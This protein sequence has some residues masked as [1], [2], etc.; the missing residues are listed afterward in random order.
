MDGKSLFITFEGIDGTGKSTQ[1]AILAERLRAFGFACVETR[2][3]GG[4]VVAEKIREL[5]KS[6][7]AIRWS[8]EVEILLL[9]AARR[10]HVDQI[11]VPALKS[12]KIVIC[13]RYLDSTRIYQGLSDSKI[14]AVIEDIHERIIGI[15]P[16]LTFILDLSPCLALERI[17]GRGIDDRYFESYGDKIELLRQG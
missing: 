10:D 3:P 14:R 16:D 12:G 7:R 8:A 1:V 6:I 13:D 5:L 17:R 4:T 9:T 2:E 15:S 11:I